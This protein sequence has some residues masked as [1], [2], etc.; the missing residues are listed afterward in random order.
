MYVLIPGRHHTLTRFQEAYLYRMVQTGLQ[1]ETDIFGNPIEAASID[2][3]IF[4]VCSANH[5]GTRRNPLSFTH[6]AMAIHDFGR[7]L[8]CPVYA[9]AIPDIGVRAD[10]AEF[11]VKTIEH[12]LHLQGPLNPENCLVASSTELGTLFQSLGYTLFG[13]ERPE[14]GE[15]I[16]ALPWEYIKQIAQDANWKRNPGIIEKLHPASINILTQYRLDQLV[17]EIFNDPVVGDDGDITETRDYGSYVRQMDTI[18]EIKW[19]EVKHLVQ[20]GRIGDIGCAVGSWI[21]KASEE[22]ILRDSDFYGIELARPLLQIC[23]Q[24]KDNREFQTPNIWFSQKNAVSGTVFKP[25]SMNTIHSSSLTHEIFSYGSLD[26]LIQFISNR[27]E[28]LV[29]GG[30]WINRDVIGPENK[31]LLVDIVLNSEDGN[32][33]SVKSELLGDGLAGFS[34]AARFQRFCLDFRKAETEEFEVE[35]LEEN[36]FRLPLEYAAEFAL[37]KDYTDNWESEMHERFCF[38]SFSQWAEA[39]EQA[40]FIIQKDSGLFTNPWIYENRIQNKIK[41]LD[42][43]NNEIKI[44]THAVF[45]ARKYQI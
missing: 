2:G 14:G 24:R 18:I 6:R 29:P 23:N 31:D 30:I 15:K 1:G 7:N 17:Q 19:E 26:D 39:L 38:W 4:A 44:P 20:P 43:E 40:G 42:S 22:S 41:I 12:S 37:T 16:E 28:E 3:L 35:Q 27:Y 10:F 45:A 21:K 9:I 25:K 8:P 13:A 11:I 33:P 5:Q 32:N 34:T 36:R